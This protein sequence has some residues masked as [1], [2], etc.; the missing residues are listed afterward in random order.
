MAT[1]SPYGVTALG[2]SGFSGYSPTAQP[3]G[4]IYRQPNGTTQQPYNQNIYQQNSNGTVS[5]KTV[6][7]NN[8][9]TAGGIVMG[10]YYNQQSNSGGTTTGQQSTV[11]PWTQPVGRNDP[12]FQPWMLGAYSP[13]AQQT[14]NGTVVN[15]QN[16]QGIGNSYIQNMNSYY[17]PATP[18][19]QFQNNATDQPW[20]FQ[21]PQQTPGVNGQYGGEQT[22][23]NSLTPRQEYIVDRLGN[24]RESGVAMN[25][26]QQSRMMESLFNDPEWLNQYAIG[27]AIG[28]SGGV[29]PVQGDAEYNNYQNLVREREQLQ[30]ARLAEQQRLNEQNRQQPTTG[31]GSGTGGSGGTGGT[32]GTDGGF[33]WPDFEDLF[34]DGFPDIFGPPGSGGTGGNT[35]GGGGGGLTNVLQQ[36]IPLDPIFT[37]DMI[38]QMMNQA[39]GANETQ[40]ATDMENARQQFGSSGFSTS[41]PAL[42]GMEGRFD[43]NRA[44]ANTQARSSIPMQAAQANA[45]HQISVLSEL[46]RQR[47]LDISTYTA[48][49][50]AQNGLLSPL[51][52]MFTGLI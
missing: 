47:G 48:L 20:N 18:M 2:A 14:P 40:Y 35:G 28:R 34:P 1:T 52:G 7:G 23:A 24:F 15:G 6:T 8:G 3:F 41:S 11:N 16:T 32:G 13:N 29:E 49:V 17:N 43:L 33:E 45:S 22:A 38:N 46:A 21:I 12:G 42:R 30:A 44:L 39:I 31:G 5:S 27:N 36:Q 50:N 37:D 10:P 19:I 25:A 4:D 9:T 26:G 51:L